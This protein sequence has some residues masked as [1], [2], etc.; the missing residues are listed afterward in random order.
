MI[1]SGCPMQGRDKSVKTKRGLSPSLVI[2][3]EYIIIK[4]LLEFD[5]FSLSYCSFIYLLYRIY[6]ITT[7]ML[8]MKSIKSI[9]KIPL[10]ILNLDLMSLITT[11]LSLGKIIM[12]WRQIHHLRD[13]IHRTIVRIELIK[14]HTKGL[15]LIN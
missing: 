15:V 7:I 2:R 11:N 12:L 5:I 8:I 3:S 6:S 4:K 10:P 13:P 9:P 1:W 14:L